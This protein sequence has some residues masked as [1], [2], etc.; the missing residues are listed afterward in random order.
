[1][2]AEQEKGTELNPMTEM[3]YNKGIELNA[4][5]I[6]GIIIQ[7]SA[8]LST[9]DSGDVVSMTAYVSL[10]SSLLTTGFISATIS[11]DWDTVRNLKGTKEFLSATLTQ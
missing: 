9:M 1:M 11:Y 7:T 4:E 6:P 5:S 10:A 8:I 3:T 2:G